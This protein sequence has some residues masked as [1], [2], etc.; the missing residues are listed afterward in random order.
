[1]YKEILNKL[2]TMKNDN[3]QNVLTDQEKQIV[4]EELDRVH[5]GQH[6]IMQQIEGSDNDP[7]LSMIHMIFQFFLQS[8]EYPFFIKRVK[9]IAQSKMACDG[10]KLRMGSQYAKP[11]RGSS[12]KKLQ[13]HSQ[14]NRSEVSLKA[15]SIQNNGKI[16]KM[17][18]TY[19][20]TDG[21]APAIPA[22]EDEIN[23]NSASYVPKTKRSGI[24]KISVDGLA[25]DKKK[26]SDPEPRNGS[27]SLNRKPNEPPYMQE[28]SK[29]FQPN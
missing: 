3:G 22:Q 29:S 6:S 2:P 20:D 1:M 11:L 24:D 28:F 15:A 17:D 10:D 9:N 19:I 7:S 25:L 12:K 4:R 27:T 23:S 5:K 16:S 21:S 14:V 13:N 26:Y 18:E 8:G